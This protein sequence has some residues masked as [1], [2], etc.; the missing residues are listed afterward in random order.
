MAL[1]GS[2]ELQLLADVARLRHDMNEM[3]NIVGRGA[4]SMQKALDDVRST[5]Q[6]L[7]GG[8][9]VGA[10][11]AWIKGAI[12]FQDQLNDLNKTT[13]ITVSKLAGISL[14]SKQT[15]SDLT[16]MAQAINKMSMEMG[17][18][19]EKFAKIGVTSK[20]PLEA[21][22]QFSEI[23]RNISDPQLRAA[24][25]AE[26]L[27][28]GWASAAPA[29][30]EGADAIER[31]V[32][33]GE[34][35][36]GITAL[37]AQM[38][39]EFNDSMSELKMALM[40]T[41]SNLAGD[42]LPLLT[43]LVKSLTDVTHE[44]NQTDMGFS[45]MTETMRAVIVFGGNV[46][47]VFR[48]IAHFIA[49]AAAQAG[50][51]LQ[52]EF[53]AAM[54]IGAI[55][56]ETAAQ[57]RKAFDAWEQRMMS[58]GKTAKGVAADFRESERAF[59]GLQ[60][61]A[62][63]GP[64][65]ATLRGFLDPEKA[66]KAVDAA[67]KEREA[68]EKERMKFGREQNIAA[69]KSMHDR[70]EAEAKLAEEAK[71]REEAFR[72]A[73]DDSNDQAEQ[74]SIK[75]LVALQDETANWKL[76]ES[77]IAAVKLA[78]MEQALAGS[79]PQDE[80]REGLIRQ[81]ET[82]RRIVALLK[83]RELR[84]ANEKAAEEAAAAWRQVGDAFVDSLMQ[85]GKSVAEY[86]KSLFRTLVLRPMLAPIGSAVGAAVG[87]FPTAANATG[88][89]ML[90]QLGTSA[91]G[92]AFNG[93]IS[94]V[95]SA[96][97]G[98]FT[99]AGAMSGLSAAGAGGALTMGGN[100]AAAGTM[101]AT[102]L[103]GAT[104]LAGAAGGAGTG[105][106]MAGVS[107]ALAAIPV[108]GWAAMAAI[109]IFSMLKKGGGPKV[110]GVAG[111]LQS[112]IGIGG[113]S[114]AANAT[115]AT[116]AAGMQKQLDDILKSLGVA[117]NSLKIGLG[118]STDPKGDSPSFV[119]ITGTRD[120]VTAFS[121][122]NRN[123]GRSEQELAEAISTMGSAAILKGLQ[124]S[125]LEGQIGDWLRGLG[126]VDA[127]SGGALTEAL[128]RVQAYAQQ[129]Q[130]LDDRMLQLTG[131][132]AE[133]L[134]ESRRREIAAI[135]ESNVAL[136]KRIHSLEDEKTKTDALRERLTSMAD[137]ARGL[138][139]QFVPDEQLNGVIAAQI[140]ET[141]TKA[142]VPATVE[143]ILGGSKQSFALVLKQLQEMGHVDGMDAM[144]EVADDFLTLIDRMAEP[145]RE[146]ATRFKE[147]QESLQGLGKDLTFFIRDL[148]TDRA[149]TA[150]PWMRQALSKANAEAD[151]TLA[152]GGDL[153]AYGRL[154]GSVQ[155]AIEAQ[156]GLTASGPETQAAIDGWLEKLSSLPAVKSYEQQSL[157]L[158][159][160]IK[161]GIAD[162]PVATATE[163]AGRIGA[164][165]LN[166]TGPLTFDQ[167]AAGLAGSD[168]Q[169]AA[170]LTAL[171]AVF[172]AT[173]A[174]DLTFAQVQ[175]ALAGKAT[176]AELQALMRTV[177]ANRDGVVTRLELLNETSRGRA[178]EAGITALW[179]LIGQTGVG[180]V[181]RLDALNTIFSR[182]D[183]DVDH[184]L[185]FPELQAALAGKA[186]DAEIKSLIT[187]VDRNGDG[188]VS[189]LELAN[190]L[191]G[192]LPGQI[193]AGLA[194]HFDAIDIDGSGFLSAAEI[195]AAL[196]GKATSADI[197]LMMSVL[198]ANGDGQI[199][200]LELLGSKTD[201]TNTNL[202]ALLQRIGTN[203]LLAYSAADIGAQFSAINFNTGSAAEWA[204]LTEVQVF[205]QGQAVVAA[206]NGL[207]L[208]ASGGTVSL[209]GSGAGVGGS[210]AGA[211]GVGG[212]AGGG[213]GGGVITAPLPPAAANFIGS[214]SLIG[215]VLG[216]DL[217]L[218]AIN[219]IMP[220]RDLFPL[221]VQAIE[222]NV[223]AEK[224]DLL[225]GWGIDHA[226]VS[227][228][229]AGFGSPL[230][231]PVYH[232]GIDSVPVT[233]PAIL[234]QGERVVST[235]DNA[236]MTE[237]LEAV[238]RN[239]ARTADAVERLLQH[240]QFA[241]GKSLRAQERAAAG[242][243]E[244]VTSAPLERPVPS[245]V[246]RR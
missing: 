38:A 188:M 131:T 191:M 102:D 160:E 173:G 22:K 14:M 10:F 88:T 93:T 206:I 98:G 164:L 194:P 224:T 133:I 97:M 43:E 71:K 223:A 245:G 113:T 28:K 139:R 211:G 208:T 199:S 106:L 234:E 179:D 204:R 66:K 118:F 72:K 222:G 8:L 145:A 163:L 75:Q 91:L 190:S 85:G 165:S 186:T 107:G 101:V 35:L 138:A 63:G 235:R 213:T 87:S 111:I 36:A 180:T 246:V 55:E 129:K 49:A 78:K 103:T 56:E 17:K 26:A 45:V 148:R 147:L 193:V 231:W 215:G 183:T 152:Q 62:R 168:S 39:D 197:A 40:G 243:E 116:A 37:D 110:D 54:Q 151:F 172:T 19:P 198:D 219:R 122:L 23:F 64:S 178:S 47:H 42:M 5:M 146:A 240:E 119:D 44:T 21:F 128:A 65:D 236:S 13:D 127:L 109:A 124:Q 9:S 135:D 159:G 34:E 176:D 157:A 212:G 20:E 130:A 196:A 238:E 217:I 241:S 143:A 220:A 32:K 230:S 4:R 82:Q 48:E 228:I 161:A 25:A 77:Q 155:A 166:V 76:L 16:G 53:K 46:A 214:A 15:G 33:R 233:G 167:F 90:G 24:V 189:R 221:I 18:A 158:L 6:G 171:G 207:R 177:D 169:I 51:F 11:G 134:A 132:A 41:A 50:L 12:D 3:N 125:N 30:A 185:K 112:G 92:S 100:L 192:G 70:W 80:S 187:S 79:D 195:N 184:L 170:Q 74:A 89:G 162:L 154:Q 81:I 67:K 136:L 59:A 123:V 141:L 227:T 232:T 242:I 120:G 202:E 94:G 140:V 142:G 200:K 225:K 57:R 84:D 181:T 104:V 27:G 205:S 153:D 126:D 216:G 218:P 237:R 201:A 121:S 29:L 1:A 156:K 174:D 68:E 117:S 182:V 137:R 150:A 149:G 144:L 209:G 73:Q 115:A 58:A 52:G 7:F 210:S 244:L 108:W 229:L 60:K 105:G 226:L 86:L 2:L 239:S 31:M 95:G 96:F 175:T 69:V 83:G 99:G 61:A 203:S 114:A